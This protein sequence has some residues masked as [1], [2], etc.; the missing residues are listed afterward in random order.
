MSKALQEKLRHVLANTVGSIVDSRV[1]GDVLV[2]GL[3]ARCRGY[4]CS[5]GLTSPSPLRSK[6]RNQKEKESKRN[7]IGEECEE[8]ERKKQ[9]IINAPTH[10]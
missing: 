3:R 1:K 8:A 5:T 9:R 4:F 7:Q 10:Y 6:K 2:P